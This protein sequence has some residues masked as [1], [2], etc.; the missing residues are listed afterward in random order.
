VTMKQMITEGSHAFAM[1][2]QQMLAT[3]LAYRAMGQTGGILGADMRVMNFLASDQYQAM[4]KLNK[5]WS[6]FLGL[7]TSLIGGAAGIIQQMRGLNKEAKATGASFTGTNTHSLT[8]ISSFESMFTSLQKVVG[9]MRTAHASSRSLAHVI[10]TSLKGAVDSGALANKGLRSQIYQMAKEAGYAGPDKIGPLKRWIDRA[11][12]SL[13]NMMREADN[14]AAAING[15][16]SKTI[17]I[18]TVQRMITTTHP[19]Y[20]GPGSLGHH[21]GKGYATGTNSATSGWH[22]VGENGPELAYLRGGERILSHGESMRAAAGGG[23]GDIVVP[24]TVELDGRVLYR[25]VQRH[26]TRRQTVAGDNG[27]KRTRR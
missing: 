27:L 18:T 21:V 11:A 24:V 5:A 14:A 12:T 6:T 16:H 15:L 9:G 3:S 23:S 1:I 4:S 20:A 7:T 19:N 10:A 17:V 8:L 26:A 13:H 22:W 2:R 25:T